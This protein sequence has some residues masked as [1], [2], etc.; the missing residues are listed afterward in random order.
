MLHVLLQGRILHVLLLQGRILHVL[1]LGGI[2]HVLLQRILHVLLLGMRKLI[3]AGWV[4]TRIE[5]LTVALIVIGGLLH[6][7]SITRMNGLGSIVL[8]G[9]ARVAIALVGS[10]KVLVR[11]HCQLPFRGKRA[12]KF[13]ADLLQFD[14]IN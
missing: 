5:A 3:K 7:L 6:Q 9:I 11:R 8:M 1:L 2:L 14:R 10:S 13:L 12:I 4:L